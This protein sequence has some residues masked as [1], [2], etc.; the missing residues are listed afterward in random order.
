MDTRALSTPHGSTEFAEVL[1]S[2]LAL[3]SDEPNCWIFNFLPS[4]N[5]SQAV[6][7]SRG[8]VYVED[9]IVRDFLNSLNFNPIWAPYCCF[10]P[11]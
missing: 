9:H 3:R 7:E 4:R 5:L 10:I 8:I 11:L 2:A 1:P 6:F